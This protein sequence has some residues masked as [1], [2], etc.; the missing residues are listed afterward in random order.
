[1]VNPKGSFHGFAVAGIRVAVIAALAITIIGLPG[2]ASSGTEGASFLDIP[3]GAGPAAMGSAYTALANDA[4]APTWNPAGLGFLDGTQF[5]GQHLSYLESMDY[6]YLS[7]AV[8]LPHPKDCSGSLF[9]GTRALGVS[10]QYLGS[11]DITGYTCPA[12]DPT[13]NSNTPTATGDFSAHYAAY[14]LSY[15]QTITDKL[16]LGATGKM[17]NAKLADVSANAYAADIGS[18]YLLKSNVQLAATLTNIGSNLTF[19]DQGDPLPLALHIAGAYQPNPR[20]NLALENAY[21]IHDAVDGFRMGA[22]WTPMP[23]VSIRVG[24]RTDNLSGLSALAGFSTGVGVRVWGQELAY[25]WVPYGDLGDTNYFSLLIK[26]GGNPEEKRNLIKYGHA[27]QRRG[28]SGVDQTSV[29]E[30]DYQQL[31]ELLN[32]SEQHPLQSPGRSSDQ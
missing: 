27:Q 8:P 16:S 25:A 14:N 13:C 3:V 20:W 15:G 28:A 24:Y 4:Y 19:I 10:A 2:Y 9:C 12:N 7:A 18:Q 5:S 23:A 30:P 22:E 29:G 6:E 21:S 31:M 17:I 26:F 11:G 1:M 32:T